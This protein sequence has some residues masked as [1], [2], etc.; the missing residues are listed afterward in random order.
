MKRK[1]IN[2]IGLFLLL[3]VLPGMSWVYLSSGLS[4]QKAKRAELR[5]FGAVPAFPYVLMNGDTI[6][7]EVLAGKLLLAFDF[8]GRPG[9]GAEVAFRELEKIHR[10]FDERK[11]VIFLF[12]AGSSDSASLAGLIKKFGLEDPGQVYAV[13]R[14]GSKNGDFGIRAQGEAA[15]TVA[16]ADSAGI[17]RQYYDFRDGN[18][19]RRSVE[20]I[21]ILMPF[22]DR[23]EAVLRREKEK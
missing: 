10:Q 7:E 15:A 11:D 6:G 4:Y 23:D 1:I 16:V 9:A 8:D 2:Y 21:A 18:R 5:R 17:I 12:L 20:H 14:P 19:V 3:V 22:R 13:V